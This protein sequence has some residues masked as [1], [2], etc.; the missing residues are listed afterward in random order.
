M[1]NGNSDVV[2]GVRPFT[3]GGT[4]PYV[5]GNG[6]FGIELGVDGKP[7]EPGY[8]ILAELAQTVHGSCGL[9]PD[10]H[11]A[12]VLFSEPQALLDGIRAMRQS[13]MGND[14]LLATL[15][16]DVGGVIEEHQRAAANPEA[17]EAAVNRMHANLA[18]RLT[19]GSKPGTG[20]RP[21]AGQEVVA[22]RGVAP[23]SLG[24]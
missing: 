2:F 8:N 4:M 1:A 7:G 3:P 9:K 5:P 18:E 15:E 6:Q 21:T 22:P 12:N 24:F 19:G 11:G 13:G 10:R 20:I 23:A 14:R 17:L 16:S